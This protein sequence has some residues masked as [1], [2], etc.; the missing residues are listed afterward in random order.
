MKRMFIEKLNLRLL[1]LLLALVM[2]ASAFVGCSGGEEAET[3]SGVT[4]DAS[5]ESPVTT[6]GIPEGY[7]LEL[8]LD[9][10]V[11]RS[12]NASE[13]ARGASIEL[14]NE[15]SDLFGKDFPITEDWKA[16]AEGALE[17]LIGSTNRPES[18]SATETLGGELRYSVSISGKTVVIAS[19]SD[20]ILPYAVDYFVNNIV[21]FDAESTRVYLP[22]E[23]NY[24]SDVFSTLAIASGGKAQYGMVYSQHANA[25]VKAEYVKLQSGVNSILGNK[26]QMIKND[27]LS[28]AGKYSSETLEILIGSTGHP[29][30]PE[31][32]KLFDY[33]ECGF[34]VVGNKIIITGRTLPATFYATERF[35]EL[36]QG[37]VSTADDGTKQILLPYA[38]PVI[39][40][41]K[42]YCNGIPEV[43]LTLTEAYDCGDD[44]VTMLYADGKK[45]DYDS[46]I[47]SAEA[48]GYVTVS[49]RTAGTES[50]AVLES[51][52]A[53]TRLFV[54]HTSD[55]LRLTAESLNTRTFPNEVEADPY[56]TDLTITQTALNY[57][58][59]GD[60]TNGM[61]YVL[62]LTDGSFVIWDGGWA[63]DAADLFLFLK[64]M[65]PQGSMPHIRM[66]I[67]THLHGDHSNCYLEFAEEY[68]DGVKLDY[69]GVNIPEIHS[70]NEGESIYSSGKL[71][72]ALVKFKTAQLVK[73]HTGMLLKMPGADIE[74]LLTQEDLGVNNLYS[75]KRND[76][77]VI[78]RILANTDK[79]ILPG[80]A[81]IVAGDYVVA[82]YGDYLQS[83]YVQVA[84]HGSINNPT[85][86][87][88]YKFVKPTYVL[89]PGAQKRYNENKSTPE[90]KYLINLVGQKN[91]F[92]A[93]GGDKTITLD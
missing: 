57:S 63:T 43:S 92:V 74:V 48:E 18:Q 62:Q 32:R 71:K 47:S 54:G 55:G 53:K 59:Q 49:S 30:N 69:V 12:E 37:S 77:S 31:G 26:T 38:E 41:Y 80:D 89:F 90:N 68:A 79:V 88:F 27:A 45:S 28:K 75:T 15:L 56:T 86:L 14:K 81:Q 91:V 70:D 51:S 60:N 40:E 6:S 29:E 19:P 58:A 16:P 9:Y 13:S 42:D 76:Q 17:I 4:S 22:S 65:A 72:N 84:H 73:L 36:L 2:L 10:S 64:K 11:V 3:S 52:S 93:D 33:D 20:A 67:F 35:L 44:V 66:W 21:Y 25:L 34:C 5:S 23:L 8:T 78:T 87:D 7:T 39:W 24:V 82:R 61:S 83:N 46:Y 1:A 85:C 50:Y